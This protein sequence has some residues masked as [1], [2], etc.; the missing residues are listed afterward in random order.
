[1]TDSSSTV[2]SQVRAVC[3]TC[4][5]CHRPCMPAL[6]LHIMYPWE[7][8]FEQD[9]ELRMLGSVQETAINRFAKLSE[10]S[11]RPSSDG[12]FTET[13]QTVQLPTD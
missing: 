7:E 11:T 10:I 5:T 6:A 12:S 1:M 8:H 3:V 4:L 9:V 13:L 2:S